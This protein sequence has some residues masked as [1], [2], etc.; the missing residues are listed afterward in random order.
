MDDLARAAR[1]VFM[2]K[3]YKRTQV[4]D[5]AAAVGLSPA[6]VYRH[7]ESKEALFHLCFLDTAID[8]D[9]AV[10]STDYVATPA[11]AETMAL[12]AD[13]LRAVGGVPRLRRALRSPGADVRVEL[14]EIIAE[15]FEFVSRNHELLA[16]IEASAS[17]LQ[18]LRE[19][20]F[21]KGRSRN[22]DD[23][24]RYL[25]RRIEDGSLRSVPDVGIASLLIR[26]SIAWFAWHG[27]GDPG[28]VLDD[29]TSLPTL[30]DVLV[31]GLVA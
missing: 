13:R 10:G 12:I 5:V 21:T 17:D 9:G 28:V 16:L 1:T 14:R 29:A 30:I 20:Y 24:T 19:L 4:A 11:A 18:D 15:Q 3:G 2:A 31:E 26:E 22:T 25:R 6:A 7:V 27:K 23:L 8:G